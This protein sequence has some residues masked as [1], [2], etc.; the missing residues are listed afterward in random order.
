MVR[1]SRRNLFG[2][3]TTFLLGVFGKAQIPARGGAK[4]LARYALTGPQQGMEAILVEVTALAGVSTVHRHP[5][6]VLGYV[7]DG[8]LKFAINGEAP[9]VIKT[10]GTF[11]EPNGALHTIGAS[12]NPNAPVRFLAF[13]VAP[14]GSSV[15]LPA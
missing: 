11:F 1:T 6:F 3:A 15:V 12:A 13:I 5:G 2:L 8:K 7:L 10:G 14:T 4:E 9:E